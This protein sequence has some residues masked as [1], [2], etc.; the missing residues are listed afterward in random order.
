MASVLIVDDNPDSCE[1]VT[2]YLERS[3][4]AVV[5]VPNGRLALH[6]LTS[7]TPDVVLLDLMMPE[8]DGAGFLQV[9]RSYLRW[10]DLPVM[11]LTA[12]PDS[13][14][15]TRA[16]SFK[17][18]HV[19]HKADMDL[20]ELLAA[21]NHVAPAGRQRDAHNVVRQPTTPKGR[22]DAQALSELKSEQRLHESNLDALT[23]DN[24]DPYLR[25]CAR[26]QERVKEILQDQSRRRSSSAPISPSAAQAQAPS[27]PDHRLHH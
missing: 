27:S 20:A 17:V 6:A 1:V 22:L 24:S 25:E 18:A 19:F 15:L 11:I 13:P 10:A 12:Y 8:M 3:G 5:C 2:R 14:Q 16:L 21:V 26:H 4:H 23:T 9:V 7:Q